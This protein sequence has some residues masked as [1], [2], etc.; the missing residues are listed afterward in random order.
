MK[1]FK[2]G[3]GILN[4][5]EAVKKI[6]AV[7]SMFPGDPLLIV[8]SAFG[9][10]TNAFEELVSA[11]Y[12]RTGE[13]Q[14]IAGKIFDYH[15]EILHGLFPGTT[16]PVYREINEIRIDLSNMILQELPASHAEFYDR[17]I[18]FGE[19]LSSK[20]VSH[21]LAETGIPNSWID[22]RGILKTDSMF[23]E[24]SVDW[25]ASQANSK[26]VIK[27][28]LAKTGGKSPMIVTQ[29]FIGSDHTGRSTS[30]GREG[31][32][33][34]ASIFAS[35][36]DACEVIIWKDV[37]GILNADPKHFRQTVKIDRISYAEATELAYYG[38][39]VIHPKT[40]KPLQNKKIPLQVRSFLD[41]KSPGTLIHA[42]GAGTDPAIPNFIFKFDQVLISVSTR[43]LS[44]INEKVFND[45][46]A[47]LSRFSIHMN[48]IQNSAL[49]LS[50]CT[51]NHPN[52][53]DLITGLQEFYAVRYNQ[54]LEL[55]TIRH[56][57]EK[58]AELVLQGKEVL[59]EQQNRTVVQ[60]V[61]R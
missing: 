16:H 37:P 21:F 53:M 9:K 41:P 57:N 2:F 17:V 56:F 32:D 46:F 18:C 4:S 42:G 1:V 60:Y 24:A 19:L 38:A 47:L 55:I 7:V 25:E 31:S 33:Y 10:T 52:M 8:V 35:L 28:L 13:P 15:L 11:V 61:V 54:G 40:V 5:A 51:D 43:D 59:L 58:A 20:I 23:R 48:I 30:L 49:T 14:V 50:F 6:P 12:N 3:G 29:G 22:V 36:L 39:K 26:R 27:P 44:F 45:V 34:T